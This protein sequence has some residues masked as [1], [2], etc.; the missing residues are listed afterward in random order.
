MTPVYDMLQEALVGGG[1]WQNVLAE[2]ER[3]LG[4]AASVHVNAQWS[5]DWVG[6]GELLDAVCARG[7]VEVSL[8]DRLERTAATLRKFLLLAAQNQRATV[9]AQSDQQR[10]VQLEAQ[11]FRRGTGKVWD[12]SDCCADSLLQL[13]MHTGVLDASITDAERRAACFANRQA[14]LGGPFFPRNLN[15]QRD[16]RAYLE[17]DRHAEAIVAF[18]MGWFARRRRMAIPAAGIELIVFS[19][20]DSEQIP[21]AR[22]R[23]CVTPGVETE[24]GPLVF[25]LYNSTGD[26]I[27][28]F[29]YDP[30]REVAPEV[31]ARS[32]RASS[33]ESREG[34]GREDRHGEAGPR[35]SGRLK[36]KDGASASGARGGTMSG[37]GTGGRVVASGFGTTAGTGI[38]D[39]SAPSVGGGG[40]GRFAVRGVSAG[41]AAVGTAAAAAAAAGSAATTPAAT[42]A[43]TAP[44][45][46]VRRTS[47]AAKAGAPRIV[48]GF[49]DERIDDV[50][51]HDANM[52]ADA[53]HRH[54]HR[55]NEGDRGRMRDA[56]NR[57]LDRSAGGPWHA[58]KRS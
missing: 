27:R 14:L 17:H 58:G 1:L 6:W 7:G 53:L 33:T 43:P 9:R 12:Q 51:V 55:V 30:V 36:R 41:G 3:T 28:G 4:N 44:L 54:E 29:H 22:S 26:G 19:R 34:E 23:I 25:R 31:V 20:F 13:L 45:G 10:W 50:R 46:R 47:G 18:F 42:V 52:E 15:G 5:A 37:N 11:G 57:D 24:R 56:D 8:E 49:G 2:L 35:R 38:A 40:A 39:A 48:M 16:N 32:P 21:V